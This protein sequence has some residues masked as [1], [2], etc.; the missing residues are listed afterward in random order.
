MKWY[1]LIVVAVL[2]LLFWPRKGQTSSG[3]PVP[4]DSTR[5]RPPPPARPKTPE[6]KVADEANANW[7]GG[8]GD[9]NKIVL[10]D[11]NL[12]PGYYINEYGGF[13]NPDTGASFSPGSSPPVY[14]L[15]AEQQAKRDQYGQN[16]G[17]AVLNAAPVN[18]GETPPDYVVY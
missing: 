9:P 6:E 3:R 11:Q 17:A 10:A 14:V 2:L 8:A 15:S 1:H 5:T 16:V 18:S 13:F 4:T 7:P 12:Y